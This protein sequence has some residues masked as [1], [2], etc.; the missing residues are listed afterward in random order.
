MSCIKCGKLLS[1]D[2]LYCP[3]CGK[4]QVR[5]K[6][7]RQRRTWGSGSIR[8]MK[9]CA[10]RPY[11]ARIRKNGKMISL[12]TFETYAQAALFL[13]KLDV[14]AASDRISYTLGQIY[15]NY[16][17]SQSYLSLEDA[18]REGIEVAWKR[19][20]VLKNE[21]MR[22]LKTSDYQYI[23]DSAMKFKRYKERT[24]EE[25]KKMKPSEKER[26]E[27]LCAQPS[28]PLGRDGKAKIQQLASLLCQE[29]MRDDIIDKNYAT[30]TALPPEELAEKRNFTQDEIDRLFEHDASDAA[31]IVLIYV[32]TGFRANELLGLPKAN[33]HLEKNMLI[34]GS[35]SA[36][37][38]N[39]RV[40]IHPRV[41]KYIEFFYKRPGSILIA[42]ARGVA[43]D[44]E[45]FRDRMFYP[46][47]DE[48][49]IPYRGEDGKNRLTLHRTRHTF[50]QM[51]VESGV[52][53]DA[54]KTILGHAKYATT[55]E[56]YGD[57]ISDDYLTKQMQKV[58][59]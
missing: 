25:L 57:K 46:L 14:D 53:P 33:V 26:Y 4:K 12:G 20:S 11:Q 48:L 36:A 2:A 52:S 58:E 5:T 44:Y 50:E 24:P 1:A 40:P 3:F 59:K 51:S 29:A 30:L 56:K 31:K 45:Q 39:R 27:K 32:Y 10:S 41:Q 9:G 7:P 54:L 42:D 16:Q 47:L 18:G 6:N 37:G 49:A 43:I 19:L 8:L 35:K 34:G 55:I 17:K 21:K 15:E 13:N 22:E 38:K 23:I 28:E